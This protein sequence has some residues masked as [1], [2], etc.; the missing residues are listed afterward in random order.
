MGSIESS[1]W[2]NY[3]DLYKYMSLHIEMDLDI[4]HTERT[5]YDLLQMM[6]DLGGV[7]EVLLIVF[8]AMAHYPGRNRLQAVISQRLYYLN[9]SIREKVALHEKER[10]KHWCLKFDSHH[11]ARNN[12][13]QFQITL[14]KF[15]DLQY[16][17]QKFVMCLCKR[18]NP[19]ALLYS[20]IIKSS[21]N[22]FNKELDVVQVVRRVGCC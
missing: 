20:Q 19:R 2:T 17:R 15:S 22:H 13:G 7:M 8:A 21:Y 12:K 10:V 5:T 16:L 18:Q 3:P 4:H 14:S 9:S 1:S 11:F 6:G